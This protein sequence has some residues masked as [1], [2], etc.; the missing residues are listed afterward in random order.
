MLEIWVPNTYEYKV[1]FDPDNSKG[2]VKM[3]KILFT[4]PEIKLLTAYNLEKLEEVDYN[5]I[6]FFKKE[7]IASFTLSS[8]LSYS[9]INFTIL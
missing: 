6:F 1:E 9:S 2:N 7:I 4:A 5:E 8:A 3:Y